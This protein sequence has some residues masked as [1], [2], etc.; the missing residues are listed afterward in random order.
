MNS[1]NKCLATIAN[2]QSSGYS[3]FKLWKED[4]VWNCSLNT[5]CKINGDMK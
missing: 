3:S 2:W 5:N 1:L 4:G